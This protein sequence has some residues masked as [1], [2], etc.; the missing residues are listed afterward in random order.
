MKRELEEALRAVDFDLDSEKL[1]LSLEYL[2]LIADW[3]KTRNL[4][5]RKASPH[6]LVE[7]LV[8]CF[9]I[10][11]RLDHKPVA[12]FGTGAGL[13]GICIAIYDKDKELLLVDPNKK[14]TSF[15][16]HVKSK[17]GLNNLSVLTERMENI[18]PRH[19]EQYK[20]IVLRALMPPKDFLKQMAGKLSSGTKI[21]FMVA[22]DKDYDLEIEWNTKYH[23]SKFEKRYDK[24]RGFLEIIIDQ[25]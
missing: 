3:N 20:N 4:V 1:K 7:H 12:D 25:S 9:L 16:I 18:E 10:N 11:E 2:Q 17:L 6:D 23:R 15:L 14:K 13:P 21:I 19:L 24:K 22:E 8:D 5:S